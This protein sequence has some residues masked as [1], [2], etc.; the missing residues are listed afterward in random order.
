MFPS[1]TRG[2]SKVLLMRYGKSTTPLSVDI[3]PLLH[4]KW[5]LMV[6]N[7]EHFPLG[8]STHTKIIPFLLVKI[9]LEH[10]LI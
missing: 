9:K 7:L 8:H 3:Q 4:T 1:V 5:Y 2:D 6:K 10:P